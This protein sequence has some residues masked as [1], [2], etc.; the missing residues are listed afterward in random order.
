M[1]RINGDGRAHEYLR[2]ASLSV[3]RGGKM[4]HRAPPV[5]E[6][7]RILS[8]VG[9]DA[10]K[11][12][13]YDEKTHHAARTLEAAAARNNGTDVIAGFANLQNSCLACHQSFRKSFVENFYGKS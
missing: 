6:N 4:L 1:R 8:F 10:A 5:G 13:R 7:L 11:F 3:A 9:V 12:K 2:R